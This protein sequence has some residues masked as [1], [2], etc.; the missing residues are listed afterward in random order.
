MS[1]GAKYDLNI[2]AKDVNLSEARSICVLGLFIASLLKS[3]GRSL[4]MTSVVGITFRSAITVG[5]IT[6]FIGFNQFTVSKFQNTVTV[7]NM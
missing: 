4:L 6:F 1:R 2:V 3:R 5:I 7:F